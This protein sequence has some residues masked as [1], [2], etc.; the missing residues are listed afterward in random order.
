[1]FL[2]SGKTAFPDQS[3][4]GPFIATAEDVVVDDRGYIYVDTFHDNNVYLERK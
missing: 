3:F 4:S 2:K 1:M